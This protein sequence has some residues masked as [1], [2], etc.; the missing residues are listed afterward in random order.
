MPPACDL[1]HFNDTVAAH[2]SLWLGRTFITG[3]KLISR[4]VRQAHP[5]SENMPLRNLGLSQ[6]GNLLH[7]IELGE[8]R[9]Q[10]NLP[11]KMNSFSFFYFRNAGLW[12]FVLDHLYFYIS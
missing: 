6:G 1:A 5:L 8:G 12:F 7:V 3:I 11:S 10:I 2:E 4:S 9:L